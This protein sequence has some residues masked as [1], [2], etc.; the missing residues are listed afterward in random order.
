MLEEYVI[1]LN[2]L[3]ELLSVI[4]A[5]TIVAS[6]GY[7]V[8]VWGGYEPRCRET[9][10]ALMGGGY[11][12]SGQGWCRALPAVSGAEP[13]PTTKSILVLSKH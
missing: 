4:Y 6:R 12:L 9:E 8:C 10:K 5:Q 11:L 2:V 3:A 1:L 13:R 7:G